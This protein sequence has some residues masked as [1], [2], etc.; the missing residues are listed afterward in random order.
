MSAQ[1][2]PNEERTIKGLAPNVAAL[3]CYVGGWISGIVFLVLEQKNRTI[4]FHALQSIIVFGILATAIAVFGG[5]PVAGA[6]FSAILGITAFIIWIILMVK[7]VNGEY[8]KIPWA[9]DL[10]EKFANESFSQ[11]PR[12]EPRQEEVNIEA[13]QTSTPQAAAAVP[14]PA[15]EAPRYASPVKERPSG[16]AEFKTRYYSGGAR[17]GRIVG[18]IFS[19]AWAVVLLIF[20]NFYNQYIAYYEP[21]QNAGT[22]WQMH[23]LITGDFSLWLPIL[24]TTLVLT[25]IG[26]AFLIAMD[27]YLLRKTAGIILDAFG[28]ATV[29]TLLV[30][31]PFNFSVIPDHVA[32][33][34]VTFGVTIVLILAAI[35]LAIGA[36]VKFIKLI[37][38]LVEGK[39]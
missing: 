5:I 38:H 2:H 14:P 37:V 36:I 1:Y 19:I 8:F 22:T 13:G 35:G 34:A 6:G 17:A 16:A 26:H 25:I 27:N 4:R 28:A 24:T 20:F 18:S 10:A 39:Y 11:T 3:L 31:F 32:A 23:T 30:I 29:I 7:A 15:A 33:D 12:P 21:V 9:G